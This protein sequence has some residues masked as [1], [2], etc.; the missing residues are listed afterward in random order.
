MN[1]TRIIFYSV[2]VLSFF[3]LSGCE[4]IFPRKTPRAGTPVKTGTTPVEIKGTIVAKVNNQPV[5]LEDLDAEIESFNQEVPPDRPAEKIDTK[6]K[7][8]T[9]LKNVVIRRIIMA[10]AAADK[11]LDRKPEVERA[12]DNLKQRILA[13]ELGR[14][15]AQAVEVTS[16]EIE[17]Y[18]NM[19][20]EELKEPEERQLREIVVVSEGDAKSIL[21]ELLQG[22]DFVVLAQSRSIT[23]SAKKGGDLG[24]IKKGVKSVQFDDVAFSSS[25]EAG[26]TS[27]YFKT[28]EGYTIL[29]LEAKRGGKAKTLTELWDDIKTGLTFLKQ[30]QKI[31]ELISKL[32]AGAKIEVIES[33]I[34]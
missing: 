12:L 26:R 25:L 8:I 9:Y 7:K 4:K 34:K 2:L 14:L 13:A 16:K 19:A 29:R 28:A 18:Y 22:G 1:N 23:A 30:Q 27:N 32:S 15:E 24:F 10:Q 21:I 31:E 17:D 33:A 20:K 11:G 6:D 3:N 5:T